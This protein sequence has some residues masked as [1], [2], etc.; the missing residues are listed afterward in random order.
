M[1]YLLFGALFLL[2]L[3]NP[4]QAQFFSLFGTTLD[5]VATPSSATIYKKKAQDNSLVPIGVGTAKLKLEKNDSNTIVVRQDG[6]RDSVRSFSSEA[7]YPDKVFN[8]FLTKRVVQLTAL[9]YDAKI[10]IN[11]EYRAN[12]SYEVEVDEGQTTTIEIVKPGFATIK[13]IYR[14]DR[15]GELPPIED[16]VE[17]Q[18][19][20]VS[21]TTAGEGVELF[22]N[23]AKLGEGDLDFIVKRGS[24]AKLSARKNGWMNETKEYCNKDGQPEPPL[25]D[26]FVLKGRLVKVSGPEEA[27]IYV[28][29]KAVGTGSMAV[30][31]PF[32]SC[33]MVKIKQT[34]FLTFLQEY[35]AKPNE[36]EPPLEENV[37]LRP[38][39]SYAASTASDQANVN[40]TI[41]VGKKLKEEQAW[42]LLSSIVL[43]YFDVLDNSDSQ[44]GYLRTAWQI[45]TWGQNETNESVVRTRV[46]LKRISDSPL[47]Y[48]L[49]IVSEKNKDG[50]RGKWSIKDDEHFD[51]W[52]RI[53]NT[54]K[55]L[56]SEAQTRLK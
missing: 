4:A 52:D 33:T 48:S 35:C 36:V 10:L 27:R 40:F 18:D 54:Y 47:R 14:W 38:D 11:G 32:G 7:D 17:L 8:I 15:G 23:D 20:K 24:C 46:I 3:S 31:V 51:S 45:K 26:K 19:R 37:V 39:G 21:I 12:R 50:L 49:K 13:R 34:G 29:E 55:D 25:F 2:T 43:N 53:L 28:N 44:T 30:Q 56:I 16:R 5:I 22:S 1:R 6:Y 9:P 41:E 42:K